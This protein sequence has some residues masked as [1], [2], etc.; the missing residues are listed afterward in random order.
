M[1]KEEEEE[2]VKEILRE[3]NWYIVEKDYQRVKNQLGKKEHYFSLDELHI[4]Y[5]INYTK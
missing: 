5:N 1:L 4:V 3:S 2:I